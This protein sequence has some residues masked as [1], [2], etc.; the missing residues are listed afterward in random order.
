[1]IKKTINTYYTDTGVSIDARIKDGRTTL[2]KDRVSA[3]DFARVKRSSV[4]Q[5]FNECKKPIAW[6]VPK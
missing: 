5:V 4:Y 2:F 6:A 3:E 1:M